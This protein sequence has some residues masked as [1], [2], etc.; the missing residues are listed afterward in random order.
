MIIKLNDK[1]KDKITGYSGTVTAKAEYITGET[2][3]LVESVDC[4]GR[5]TEF[6][7]DESRLEK[8][9]KE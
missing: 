6:W 9:D 1:M 8:E 2:R 7:Y 3:Y 4:T 5:P